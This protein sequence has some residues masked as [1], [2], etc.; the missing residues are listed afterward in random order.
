MAHPIALTAAPAANERAGRRRRWL[1][2]LVARPSGLIGLIIITIVVIAAAGAPLLATHDPEKQDWQTR[3]APPMTDGRDGGLHPLGT[4]ALGRDIYSRLVFGARVSVAVGILAVALRGSMGV[5]IGL[6]S[7][8]HRGAIDGVLM[9]LADVQLAIPF[10][11]LAIAIM[12]IIGTGFS[13][14]VLVLGITGW[15]TYGRVVRSEVL[16]IRERE[17][18]EAA[19]AIGV[20]SVPLMLRH[21]LP[22]V[23][24]SIIVISTLEVAQMIAAEAALSFL[25]LGIQPPTPSWGG[26]VADGRDLIYDQW[27]VSAWPGLAIFVTVLG[28]NLFGDWLRDVLDPT[29]R[30]GATRRINAT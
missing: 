14:T 18:V 23:S 9:R 11:V 19:R 29:L 15:V 5:L 10:L 28:I 13:K 21:I 3:L 20:P 17:F 1:H 2:H 6:V 26:M 27:W 16:S 8:Y 22:N 30:G 12:A 7:G 4:D 25:G 24:S